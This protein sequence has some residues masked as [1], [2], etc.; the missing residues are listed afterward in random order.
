MLS[1]VCIQ[2]NNGLRHRGLNIPWGRAQSHAGW[3]GAAAAMCGHR[4][5][6]SHTGGSRAVAGARRG[7]SSNSHVRG[8]GA[9]ATAHGARRAAASPSR[10]GAPQSWSCHSN[11]MPPS[12]S[13]TADEGSSCHIGPASISVCGHERA[14]S[15]TI[16]AEAPTASQEGAEQLRLR[17]VHR[18]PQLRFRGQVPHG[19]GAATPITCRPAAVPLQMT[20]PRVT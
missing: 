17:M 2:G 13:T 5:C 16:V 20:A 7:S 10:A 3:S 14:R 18:G 11:H 8:S 4:S 6:R 12:C 19:A 15:R 1:H 9:V